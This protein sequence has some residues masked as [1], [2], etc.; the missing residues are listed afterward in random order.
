MVDSS[1]PSLWADLTPESETDR[2]VS[3]VVDRT[4]GEGGVGASR[5]PGAGPG[6]EYAAAAVED[7]RGLG[8]AAWGRGEAGEP[9]RA[10]RI[11]PGDDAIAG[12]R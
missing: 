4:H 11:P 5:L 3:I 8:G 6:T 12:G 9:V 2:R 10:V 7:S 1:T